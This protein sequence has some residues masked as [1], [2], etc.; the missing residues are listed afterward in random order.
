MP[1][2][3]F[4]ARR[5]E[6]ADL[7]ARIRVVAQHLIAMCESLGHIQRSLIVRVQLDGDVTKIG[8]ALRAKVHNDVD[9]RPARAPYK[10]RLGRRRKLEVHASQRASPAV[11]RDVRLRDD[12]L[13]AVSRKLLLAESA[14]EKP[15]V[16]LVPL[17]FDDVGA[18]QF[19]FHKDHW[20]SS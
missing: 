15:S 7:V 4:Q 8:G 14:R 6:F 3:A 19:R 10:F 2:A 13:Q 20:T 9:N 5:V 12:R 18:I 11:R 17:Q 1:Q 16:I